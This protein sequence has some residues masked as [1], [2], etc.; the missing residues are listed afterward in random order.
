MVRFARLNRQV[1]ARNAGIIQTE[2]Q[3][4]AAPVIYLGGLEQKSILRIEKKGKRFQRGKIGGQ[5][6]IKKAGEH[7]QRGQP[8]AKTKT[9][10]K[11]GPT[12]P[13]N[14]TAAGGLLTA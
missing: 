10:V 1:A 9:E 6:Y 14:Q 5:V 4:L 3:M 2:Q 13:S 12:G 8:Q 11:T 7:N